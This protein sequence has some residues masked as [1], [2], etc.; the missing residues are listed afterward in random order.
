MTTTLTACKLA[1]LKI[2]LGDSSITDTEV[3][4]ALMDAICNEEGD[5]KF[6]RFVERNV[7]RI[8]KGINYKKDIPK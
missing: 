7:A 5:D 2:H 1:Y 4:D 3:S 6:C 8:K